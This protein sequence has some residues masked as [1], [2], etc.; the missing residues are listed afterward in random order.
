MQGII[1]MSATPKQFK[2]VVSADQIQIS[3]NHRYV[4]YVS[5]VWTSQYL[6]AQFSTVEHRGVPYNTVQYVMVQNSQ[7]LFT[8]V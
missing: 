5:Q 7:V 3:T 4:G 8:R 2:N 1:L 6:I